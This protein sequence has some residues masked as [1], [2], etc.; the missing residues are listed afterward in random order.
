VDILVELL[1]LLSRSGGNGLLRDKRQN[2]VMARV[3]PF[4]A[5][6]AMAEP[7]LKQAFVSRFG[8]TDGVEAASEAL[9]YAWEHWNRVSVMEN[10]IGYLYRVGSSRTRRIRRRTPTLPAVE[11]SRMPDVDPELPAALAAL[12]ERQRMLVI[13]VHGLGWTQ[14]EAAEVLEI[15]R[16]TVKN[17]LDRG[18]AR[19]RHSL[20]ET[21]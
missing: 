8:R 12:S 20:K 13:L 15:S 1:L 11:P 5:F 2:P 4:D 21:Q 17:H 3:E 7:R 18:L 16:T 14:R 10:P 9:A 19:L 6:V